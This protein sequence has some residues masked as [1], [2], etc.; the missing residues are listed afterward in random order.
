MSMLIFLPS[1]ALSLNHSS[2]LKITIYSTTASK[3]CHNLNLI[4]LEFES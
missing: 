3:T 1:A 4:Y 2:R